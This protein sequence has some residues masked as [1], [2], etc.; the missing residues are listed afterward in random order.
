MN[1]RSSSGQRVQ[2]LRARLKEAAHDAILD[3]AEQVIGDQGID[4][5]MEA[6][7]ARAGVAVGTLYN[8]FADRHALID[9]LSEARRSALVGRIEKAVQA[10]SPQ[11]FEAQLLAL[12]AAF[13]DVSGS[14]ARYRKALIE[15]GLTPHGKKRREAKLQLQPLFVALFAQAEKEGLLAKGEHWLHAAQLMGLVRATFELAL[16]HPELMP[17]E[18]VPT[19][20][21]ATYLHGVSRKARP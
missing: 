5:G 12:V 7:A 3:A 10:A 2:P 13:C 15:A 9:A 20:V 21:V 18:R 11:G 16:E 17:L 8:H 14:H 6:I 4:A 19:A 1:P